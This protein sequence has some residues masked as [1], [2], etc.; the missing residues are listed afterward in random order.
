MRT[1]PRHH[2]PIHFPLCAA[3]GASALESAN[4]VGYNENA[5]SG[6]TMLT[7]SFK[8]ITTAAYPI[9]NFVVS[10]SID[11]KTSI[12]VLDSAGQVAGTYYWYNDGGPGY[13]AGWF[14]INGL[15]EAGISLQ[16]GEA[17]LFYTNESGVSVRSSGEVPGEITHAVT[18]FALLGNG[19]PVTIDVDSMTVSGSIDA[20]TSIQVL[21]SAGQVT[22]T[23]YWYNDGGPGYP[24]GWFDINGLVEAGIQLGAGESVLF[25]TNETGVSATVP[26]AL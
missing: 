22:G 13:P 25:Y 14:D 16:P 15:V 9:D 21:D 19:S 12:Q 8:N 3:V 2:F 23:Y 1:M 4:V 20:K 17:V 11:A 7:P 24:A 26:A 18:G 10:G 5:V 6:F